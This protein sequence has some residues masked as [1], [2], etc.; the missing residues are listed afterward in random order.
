MTNFQN[1]PPQHAGTLILTGGRSTGVGSFV[2]Q[3]NARV[4]GI[5]QPL[6][7][8]SPPVSNCIPDVKKNSTLFPPTVQKIQL[9]PLASQNVVENSVV[10]RKTDTMAPVCASAVQQIAQQSAT[11]CS[12][13]LSAA[14]VENALATKTGYCQGKSL[15][16]TDP[17]GEE[18]L[19]TAIQISNSLEQHVLESAPHQ[20]FV[21]AP[22]SQM[23]SASVAEESMKSGTFD[24]SALAGEDVRTLVS[25]VKSNSDAQSSITDTAEQSDKENNIISAGRFGYQLD[26]MGIGNGVQFDLK[27]VCFSFSF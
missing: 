16:M 22:Q 1:Q 8:I 26:C 7:A 21:D 17:I 14:P 23:E 9:L 27:M 2:A 4:T 11:H 5:N 6:T 19:K 15:V 18:T 3:S 20:G 24:A 12:S 13:I 25:M 10:E